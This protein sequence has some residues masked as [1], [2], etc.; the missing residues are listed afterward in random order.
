[1]D[2][3]LIADEVMIADEFSSQDDTFGQ[4][5][6]KQPNDVVSTKPTKIHDKENLT[7]GTKPKK[8]KFKKLNEFGKPLTDQELCHNELDIFKDEV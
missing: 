4:I 2:E 3:I 6:A 5:V 1:M 8:F 7:F